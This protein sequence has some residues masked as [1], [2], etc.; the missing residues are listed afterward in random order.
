[1]ANKKILV[2]DDDEAV[3]ELVKLSL[4]A[5]GK[6][7]VITENRGSQGVAASK[8]ARPDLILLDIFFPDIQ[9]SE[10]ASKLKALNSKPSYFLISLYGGL[11]MVSG[12]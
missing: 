5:T 8:I 7:E 11:Q 3:A 1:M 9:G 6:Y 4:E 2:I 10:I 12:R